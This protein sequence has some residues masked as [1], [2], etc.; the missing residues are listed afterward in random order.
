MCVWCVCGSG[1]CGW[2]VG[3]VGVETKEY[4]CVCRWCVGVVCEGVCGV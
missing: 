3:G 2:C 4:I 1:V